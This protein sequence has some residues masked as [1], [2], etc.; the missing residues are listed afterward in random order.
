[1]PKKSHGVVIVVAAN[2][3]PCLISLLQF[4][5]EKK[6][7]K[8]ASRQSEVWREGKENGRNEERK[9]R[10]QKDRKNG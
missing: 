10:A 3:P 7:S 4:E 6:T 9:A 1:M 2:Y 5:K 8:Q